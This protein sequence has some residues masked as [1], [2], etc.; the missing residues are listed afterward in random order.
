MSQTLTPFEMTIDTIKVRIPLSEP[1]HSCIRASA[2]ASG[3]DQW[4]KV[5]L[6]SGEIKLIRFRGLAE[7]DIH[8]YH[9][10]VYWDISPQF[11]DGETTLDVELSL[12]KLWYGDNIRLLHDP[13]KAL[14]LLRDH[15]NRA[16]GL[17][18]RRQ[19][20]DVLTWLVGRLDVCY[21]WDLRTQEM[22]QHFLDS[23]KTQRFPYKQPVI[24]TTS[25]QF[26]GGKHSTYSAKVYLKLPE[27]EQHDAKEMRKA[28]VPES[29]INFRK[30]LA[31]GILRFE[32]TLRRQWLKRNGISTVA[33]LVQPKHWIEVDKDLIEKLTPFYRPELT[34]AAIGAYYLTQKSESGEIVLFQ[35]TSIETPVTDGLYVYAPEMEMD[36]GGIHYKH[37]SGGMTFRVVENVVQNIL[38]EMLEKMVGKDAA[39]GI[40]DKV[41]EKLL[42]AYKPVTAANL[43]AFWL[44]VQKFGSE[45]AKEVYGKDAFYYKKRQL[46]KAGVSLLEQKENTILMKDFFSQFSMSIPSEYIGNSCDDERDSINVLNIVPRL[47]DDAFG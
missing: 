23:L 13:L 3:N 36:I 40:A 47:S 27:F 10:S 4:A 5:S 45:S 30:R 41:R 26:V 34:I 43:T 1:Q 46:Q 14:N 32:V 15:L 39:M 42:Q 28:R 24:R 44:Y 17:K 33:N 38:R 7:T 8:S 11:R 25:I 20:P 2:I 37:P 12:P 6:S 9:R 31:T 22:A 21:T 18:T 16:F 29:E 35:P 19:L